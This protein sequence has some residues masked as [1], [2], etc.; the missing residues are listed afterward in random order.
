MPA[1]QTMA[2]ILIQTCRGLT[3]VIGF[4]PQAVADVSLAGDAYGHLGVPCNPRRRDVFEGNS[5]LGAAVM[6]KGFALNILRTEEKETGQIRRK[7]TTDHR[8]YEYPFGAVLS[9]KRTRNTARI[10]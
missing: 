1:N 9:A 8:A 10:T 7:R 2:P 3:L 5:R 6:S 4:V